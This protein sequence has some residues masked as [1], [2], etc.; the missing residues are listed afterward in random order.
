MK[1][2]K[3]IMFVGTCSDA[4]KSVIN[5]G[6]CRILKQD[7]YRPAPFKAQNMSL[8]SYAT[9]EGFEIGRAQATQAEACEIA[10]H[11]D[12]NPVL[13][14]PSGEMMSQVILN[15]KP[16][17]NRSAYEYFRK[18]DNARLFDEAYAAFERLQ[19]RYS[20]I[21]M[22][23]AGSISELNLKK[24]D[25]VNMRMAKRVGADVYLVADIDRGGVFASVY[26]SIM[27]LEEEERQL[28]KGIIINKFRGD[29]RLFDEGRQIIQDLTGIPVVGVVPYFKDI[30]IEDED[31]VVLDARNSEAAEGKVNIAVVKLQQMSNFTDF[32]ALQFDK[33]VHVYYTTDLQQI[34]KADIV[35]LPGSKSTIKD[36]QFIREKQIPEVLKKMYAAG[37][38]VIG[39][40]GGYQMLG[41]NISDP[42][43]IEGAVK[44]VEGIGLLPMDT[45]ITDEKTTVQQQFYF[46]DDKHVCDG[47]EIHMGQ[48]TFNSNV[49]PLVRTMDGHTDG[50]YLSERCWGTYMHG[51]LD[52]A[53]VI[54]HL[55]RPF[56]SGK[57]DIFCYK[58]FKD[59]EYNRLAKHLRQH[60][61]IESI[62][63]SASVDI[64]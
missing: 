40:C 44:S 24:R 48:S 62:Y 37:K 9:P 53:T 7:G 17:G 32:N 5:A 58:T 14:K 22:E 23:G 35:I 2:L 34:E 43:Q 56:S 20:P 12:M 21:V 27:L 57:E 64:K 49:A 11:T 29:V 61:N 47:Y 51:I 41:Q 8:N 6:F 19:K 1:E 46:M 13:L 10:C 28:I 52:N 59:D 39:I 26:G 33:R 30:Y 54:N 55:L 16:V 38:T 63:E 15:G 42:E 18:D 50:V 31:S 4:G 36:L 45:V 25:I 3:P 60:V